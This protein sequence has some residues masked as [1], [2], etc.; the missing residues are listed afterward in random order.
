MFWSYLSFFVAWRLGKLSY[1]Q[2][3]D[4]HLLFSDVINKSIARL[5]RW[6]ALVFVFSGNFKQFCS[7]NVCSFNS[8]GCFFT[9]TS[10]RKKKIVWNIPLCIPCYE[11]TTESVGAAYNSHQYYQYMVFLRHNEPYHIVLELTIAPKQDPRTF[12]V[13]LFF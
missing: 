1:L 12:I 13:I 2:K 7:I 8:R 3:L 5:V 4:N 6:R 9:V 10:F 11:D